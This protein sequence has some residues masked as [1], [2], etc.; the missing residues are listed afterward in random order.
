M[1]NSFAR[2]LLPRWKTCP[3]A[4]SWGKSQPLSSWLSTWADSGV[5][6]ELVKHYSWVCL[7][8]CFPKRLACKL[9]NWVGKIHPLCSWVPSNK[10]ETQIQQKR[11]EMDFVFLSWCRNS[12]LL[13]PL[14]IRLSGLRTTGLRSVTPRISD[15][16]PWTENYNISYSE[17]FTIGAVPQSWYLRVSNLPMPCRG[18]SQPL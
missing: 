12:L 3:Q 2:L 14:N 8:A 1:R 17:A 11:P 18:I 13:L 16:W 6:R 15:L 9:V 5:P 7:W 4:G 10:L